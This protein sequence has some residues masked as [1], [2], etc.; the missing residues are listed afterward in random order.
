MAQEN[1]RKLIIKSSAKIYP[2]KDYLI[3]VDDGEFIIGYRYFS[4]VYV[5]VANSVPL[6]YLYRLALRKK[7]FLIDK[8]GYIV[9]E[10]KIG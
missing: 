6:K 9:G 7:V 1:D 8:D 3:I 10:V 4:E 5:S 2:K